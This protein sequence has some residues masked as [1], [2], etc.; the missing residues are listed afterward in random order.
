[1]EALALPSLGMPADSFTLTFD[2][3]LLPEKT[4]Q[5]FEAVQRDAS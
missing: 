2:G 1:M 4:T 5:V 3:D